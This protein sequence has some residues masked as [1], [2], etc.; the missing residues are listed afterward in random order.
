MN[1][2]IQVEILIRSLTS[3]MGELVDSDAKLNAAYR[4]RAQLVAFLTRIFPALLHRKYPKDNWPIVYIWTPRGQLSWHISKMDLDLFSHLKW[5]TRENP[6]D[7][8]T[9]AEKY[10]RLAQLRINDIG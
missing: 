4:E 8:H 1:K 3:V 7:G 6:W 9:T 5:S 2:D 10:E